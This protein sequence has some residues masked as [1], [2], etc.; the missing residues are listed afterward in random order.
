MNRVCDVYYAKLGDYE[1]RFEIV[2]I[3]D[4]GY[5]VYNWM[6]EL[7]EVYVPR[8]RGGFSRLLPGRRW[9]PEVLE[10]YTG[11]PIDEDTVFETVDQARDAIRRFVETNN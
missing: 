3:P 5:V 2:E 4:S 11:W 9:T 1:C 8:M 7:I 6:L 10:R